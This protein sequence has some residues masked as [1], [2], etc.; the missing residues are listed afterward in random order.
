MRNMRRVAFARLAGGDEAAVHLHEVI[1]ER[2]PGPTIGISAAV[3]GDEAVGTQI[4]MAMMRR[5]KDSEL[6]GRLLLLPVANPYSFEARTRH[7][8]IDD[9]NLNRVFPGLVGGWF[10]EQLAHTIVQEFLGRVEVLIDLH[11]GGAR[12][13][14]DYVYIFN[15]EKLSRSFDSKLLYRPDSV[16]PGT[17]YG[18]TLSGLAVERNI[19]TVTVELGGGAIDQAPFVARG[20]EG[21]D[22]AL[23]ALGA[24]PGEPRMRED[25][26]VLSRIDIVRPTEGGFLRT[27]AP[28]LG[29]RIE[30]GAVLGRVFSPY[31]FDEL[32]VLRNSLAKGWMVLAHL[33]EN[34]VQPGDYAYM[35]GCE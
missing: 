32:E 10:S 25:Q 12:P 2:G 3:H 23:R 24:L 1:G 35:V 13:T 7:N 26:I 4:V 27:E 28:P 8:P 5:L 33:S 29:E 16:S 11:A 20:A 30:E 14:A 9:L 17:V 22:N 19:P 21:L 34:L 15:D 6:K 31:T 18:G